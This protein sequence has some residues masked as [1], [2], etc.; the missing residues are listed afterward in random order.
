[1]FYPHKIFRYVVCRNVLVYASV[2]LNR[3]TKQS[4]GLSRNTRIFKILHVDIVGNDVSRATDFASVGCDSTS[5]HGS[6][7]PTDDIVVYT[8]L[9]SSIGSEC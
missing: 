4:I 2:I 6:H 5:N 9:I 1:M 7:I 3:I 8:R